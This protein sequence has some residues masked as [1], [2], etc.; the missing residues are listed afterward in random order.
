MRR[1]VHV[2]G[3]NGV[4]VTIQVPYGVSDEEQNEIIRQ[5]LLKREM[6]NFPDISSRSR[7]QKKGET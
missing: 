5:A 2:I 1:E 6:K 4:P 7:P 3:R